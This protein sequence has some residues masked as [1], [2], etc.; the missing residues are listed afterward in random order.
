MRTGP[1]TLFLKLARNGSLFPGAQSSRDEFRIWNSSQNRL[2]SPCSNASLAS[3][4]VVVQICRRAEVMPQP[5]Y[6]MSSPTVDLSTT[7]PGLCSPPSTPVTQPACSPQSLRTALDSKPQVVYA[8]IDPTAQSLHVGHLIPLMS[9][10]H[11]RL[12]GHNIIPL[13]ISAYCCTHS[14]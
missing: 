13:V 2:A 10:L 9:L 11:F 7:S 5:I 12:R 1:Q 8:G 14:E 4:L 6:L 3:S